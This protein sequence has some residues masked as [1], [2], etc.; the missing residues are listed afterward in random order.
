MHRGEPGITLLSPFKIVFPITKLSDHSMTKPTLKKMEISG[1]TPSDPRQRVWFG[2]GLAMLGA[3]LFSFKPI[4]VKLIYQQEVDTITIL[5][6]RMIFA[7]PFY[8]GVGIWVLMRGESAHALD[9]K[10]IAQAAVLGVLGYYGAAYCDLYGL[11]FVSTQLGRMI[12]FTY[13]TLV[14]ILGWLLLG[15]SI[16]RSTF[17]VLFVSYIGIGFIFAHDMQ[18]YGEDV[19]RGAIWVFIS[20]VAFSFFLVFSKPLIGQ[21]GSK[22][23][24]CVAMGAA[25]VVVI[26]HYVVERVVR[27]GDAALPSFD[28]LWLILFLAVFSTVLPSFF[29]SAAISRIGA[30]KTSIAACIGPVMTSA[31]AV[32]LLE[33]VFGWYHLS[34]LILVLIAVSFVSL[35]RSEKST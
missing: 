10:A 12:L 18:V 23:F 27:L 20:A 26:G 22:L 17:A 9:H 13:P 35:Q 28:A 4:L 30:S 6:Y 11:Q 21:L 14:T 31:L 29:I 7:L 24:T 1:V 8:L 33:E 15:Y 32:F 16:R 3:F 5:T 19:I 34:G 2:L 25:A